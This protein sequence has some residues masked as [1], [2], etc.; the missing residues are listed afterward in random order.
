MKAVGIILILVSS[1][2]AGLALERESGKGARELSSFISFVSTLRTR[3]ECYL[4]SPERVA[5]GCS[6]VS[7]EKNGFLPALRGG[8]SLH[9]S[10]LTARGTLS[11]PK[12]ADKTLD[13]L[14]SS[15]GKGYL[16]NEM[17]ATDG[18]LNTLKG[19]LAEE[20]KRADSRG[21]ALK[22]S[23]PALGMGLVILLI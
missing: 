9:A 12:S 16:A 11:I 14:F 21:R 20:T 10:Y 8:K 13:D 3:L 7:L 4:E 1:F 19:I 23:A 2:L 15:F 5:S 18:A 17:R 22:I 6:D